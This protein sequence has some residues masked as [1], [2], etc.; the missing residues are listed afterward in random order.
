MCD[1]SI[2]SLKPEAVST[3][4]CRINARGVSMCRKREMIMRSPEKVGH[5]CLLFLIK[6]VRV[7]ETNQK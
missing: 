1:R 7:L 4:A 5:L 6:V 3:S 2:S